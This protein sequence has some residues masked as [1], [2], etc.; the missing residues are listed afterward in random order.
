VLLLFFSAATYVGWFS[1]VGEPTEAQGVEAGSSTLSLPVVAPPPKAI[2]LRDPFA[3]ATVG[4]ARQ[5]PDAP[6]AP[7]RFADDVVPNIGEDSDP[8]RAAVG[9]GDEEALAGRADAETLALRATI[10][11][12]IPVAYVEHGSAMDIV[13]IGDRLGD[14]RVA[15]IDLRGVVFVDGSRLALTDG[16]SPTPAS[17]STTSAP[18]ILRLDQLRRLLGAPRAGRTRETRA[19]AAIGAPATPAASMAAYPTPGPLRTVDARGI[20][21][22][23]NPT[24]DPNAPTPYP[25]PYPYAPPR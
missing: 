13:R 4:H 10:V 24:S 14:H 15:K 22:G 1:G 21:A 6:I 19:P 25:Y 11:G 12:P 23:V 18:V 2:V 17:P 5:V 3:R 9:R 8:A 7:E 20:P 16:Y